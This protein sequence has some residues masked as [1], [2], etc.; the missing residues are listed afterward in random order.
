MNM[1]ELEFNG[2]RVTKKSADKML[3]MDQS[4]TRRDF[5]NS[6]LL[7]SGGSL[8]TSASPLQLLAED[9][10]TGYGGVGDY[11]FSN[12]NTQAVIEAGHTI[13]DQEFDSLPATTVD[14]GETFDCVVVGGG[15]S[16]LAAALFFE[17]QAGAGKKC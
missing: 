13:R 9:D 14:T 10:F 5:L 11:R 2:D 8:L 12:G 1:R 4:V 17:R 7:A 6:V 15:I 16:G 3:G